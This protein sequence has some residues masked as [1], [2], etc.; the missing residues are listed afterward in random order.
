M[1]DS[2]S[3]PQP[4]NRSLKG[5][6]ADTGLESIEDLEE[7]VRSV[8][9]ELQASIERRIPGIDAEIFTVPDDFDEPLLEE[10]LQNFGV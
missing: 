6:W 9:R 4:E 8:R 10:M 3:S 2:D 7:E 5:I 1:N